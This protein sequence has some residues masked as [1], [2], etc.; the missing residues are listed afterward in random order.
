MAM[1]QIDGLSQGVIDDPVYVSAWVKAA[2]A[3][4]WEYAPY[5][6]PIRATEATAPQMGSAMFR[7]AYGTI[8]QH[9]EGFRVFTPTE[10]NRRYVAIYGHTAYASA[11]MWVGVIEHEGFDV[12]DKSAT[13][14]DASGDQVI[15][16]WGLEYL[17]DRRPIEGAVIE[18]GTTTIDRS[19]TFNKR[20]DR[21][22][23]DQGNR[24]TS[25]GAGG[26]YTFSVDGEEWTHLDIVEYVLANYAWESI[27]LYLAGQWE[28][29][30]DIVTTI[31]IEGLTAFEALNQLIN[32]KRGLGWRI[33]TDGING[34][35]VYVYSIL[36]E[37][38]VLG[39]TSLPENWYQTSV[40]M[41]D[42]PRINPRINIVNVNQYDTI[43]V[44]GEP[45]KTVFS[46]GVGAAKT[47]TAPSTLLPGWDSG[48]ET[49]Y[50]SAADDER[51]TDKH[52]RVF[53]FF[54]MDSTWDWATCIPLLDWD[55]RWDGV[56]YST[57]YWNQGHKFERHLPFEVPTT[58]ADAEPEYQKP[59]ALIKNPDENKY[60]Y[61]DRLSAKEDE[62]WKNLSVRMTD[63]EM[64]IT[65]EGEYNHYIG[66][67]HFSG[68][69]E[70][71][72]VFDYDFLLATMFIETDTRLQVI[73]PVWAGLGSETSKT[74]QIN[75][76]DAEYWFAAPNTIEGLLLT[77]PVYNNSGAAEVLRDD[78]ATLR[79]IAAMAQAWYGRPRA[80]L[81]MRL[82]GITLDYQTSIM[83]A[84]IS[85]AWHLEPVQTV[86]TERTWDFEGDTTLVRTGYAEL[87]VAAAFRG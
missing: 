4:S 82:S 35:G 3:D 87:D 47:T 43:K 78:S 85:S 84:S 68:D 76:P 80:T 32:R 48:E 62:D 67:N 44:M 81:E 79:G 27:P 71:D 8:Q 40:S 72:P 45:I 73:A 49:T 55:A 19:P 34:I 50:E 20:Y 37:P 5:L 26:V 10:L 36:S 2:W 31:R 18:G 57:T 42:D 54:K 69:T 75:V 33:L 11:L 38:L 23:S 53:Q 22:L 28:V 51:N 17:F 46:A 39:E 24:S 77:A 21:G 58:Q 65:V 13:T 59:F 25:V 30:D 12:H 52:D 83:I 16:A 29:L 6:E 56:S 63:R 74:L 64:G 41:D 1:T 15:S 7:Y 14:G 9:G 61:V 70:E 60:Y 86:V 66:D